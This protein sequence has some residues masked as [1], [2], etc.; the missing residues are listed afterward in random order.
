ME[1]SNWLGCLKGTETFGEFITWLPQ[2]INCTRS[3]ETWLDL[4]M[5]ILYSF[6]TKH[7]A[8]SMKEDF[9]GQS[10]SLH[11]HLYVGGDE[12]D[13]TDKACQI[14]S[15]GAEALNSIRVFSGSRWHIRCVSIEFISRG[16][17]WRATS[18]PLSSNCTTN[19]F[20]LGLSS[21]VRVEGG[22]IPWTGLVST[23][24]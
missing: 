8:Q 15:C 11:C 4:K 21:K 3:T 19:P 6:F 18:R 12:Q 9:S 10:T 7:T 22:L 16:C 1:K 14:S 24:M 23:T 2:S 17:R 20:Y 5:I 13:W